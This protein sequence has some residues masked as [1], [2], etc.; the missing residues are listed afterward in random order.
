[1]EVI[2][3]FSVRLPNKKEIGDTDMPSM[4]NDNYL[5]EDENNITVSPVLKRLFGPL[6]EKEKGNTDMPL[7]PLPLPPSAYT[8]ISGSRHTADSALEWLKLFGG[9]L[10]YFDELTVVKL[11]ESVEVNK[12]YH[13]GTYTISFTNQ[14]DM[15]ECFVEYYLDPNARATTLEFKPDD[16][17]VEL[18]KHVAQFYNFKY[19]DGLLI[20]YLKLEYIESDDVYEVVFNA[21]SY[22]E[23]ITIAK[24]DM[25]F[26]FEVLD[27]KPVFTVVRD[28]IPQH[29]F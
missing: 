21:I 7:P 22:T 2:H 14:L 18:R 12:G 1:M 24:Q 9:T 28:I 8:V 13:T 29:P 25:S 6:L 27:R 3:H 11:P 19:V 20:E 23:D 26:K 15:D 5:P 10:E 16:M 4:I 17:Y